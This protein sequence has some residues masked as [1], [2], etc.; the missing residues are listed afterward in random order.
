M[1]KSSMFIYV[2]LFSENFIYIESLEMCGCHF[3]FFK[4]HGVTDLV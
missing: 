4:T 2:E 3:F 1:A